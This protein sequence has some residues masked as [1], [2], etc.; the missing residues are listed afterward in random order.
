MAVA[1]VTV[2]AKVAIVSWNGEAR[3]AQSEKQE[4][5]DDGG[6][7]RYANREALPSLLSARRQGSIGSFETRGALQSAKDG[8]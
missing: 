8:C 7:F 5:D 4:M 1:K 2:R 6:S 3:K